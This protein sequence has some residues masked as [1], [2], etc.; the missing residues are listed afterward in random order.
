MLATITISGRPTKDPVMMQTKNNTQ[1]I[2]LD[3]AQSQG[4]GD[5]THTL[6]FNC[7]FSQYLAERLVKAKVM[8][9]TCLEITGR[10]DSKEF[11]KKDGSIGRSLEIKVLD[12]EFAIS[13]KDGNGQNAAP[14]QNMPQAQN[15]QM[16]QQNM[17]QTQ[18]GQM[19][20][21]NMPQAQGYG[22]SG[23]QGR[24]ASQA[25]AQ[26]HAMAGQNY[27]AMQQGYP[28]QPPEG[29][30]FMNVPQTYAGQ[31]PFN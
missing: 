12:W 31:L 23:Y 3:I 28:M 14:P 5:E 4:F 1:Y 20:Q 9:G 19:P 22:Q 13:N 10:F 6:F 11:T 8:K 21:Q 7:Y 24:P 16:P 2:M 29:N 30:G 25:P 17:P 27:G 18:G 15:G 26:N